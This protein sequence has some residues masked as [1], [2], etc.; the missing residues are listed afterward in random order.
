MVIGTPRTYIV[1]RLSQWNKGL[2]IS[3]WSLHASAALIV[4]DF[5][6]T[7][8]HYRHLLNRYPGYH[9]QLIQTSNVW[10]AAAT[11]DSY[12]TLSF[13]PSPPNTPFPYKPIIPLTLSLS[14][15]PYH[16]PSTY[17]IPKLLPSLLPS[18]SFLQYLSHT[19]PIQT[20]LHIHTHSLNISM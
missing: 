2:Y 4:G 12:M 9:Q 3:M 19:I 5:I 7:H 14:L 8:Q 16:L 18:H 20:H 11:L 15:T 6:P 10:N 13:S 1:S 17:S